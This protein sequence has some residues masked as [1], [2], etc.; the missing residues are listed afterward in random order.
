MEKVCVTP[1]SHNST[2]SDKHVKVLIFEKQMIKKYKKHMK[3]K[4]SLINKMHK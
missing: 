2:V 3:Y 4:K 1:S